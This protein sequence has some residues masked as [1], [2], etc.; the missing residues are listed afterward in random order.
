MAKRST[1]RPPARSARL[2]FDGRCTQKPGRLYLH[3]FDW[4]KDRKLLV[5]IANDVRAAY[6]LGKPAEKLE[7]APSADGKTITL[8]EI[9]PDPNATVVVVEIEGPLHVTQVHE[10][11]QSVGATP[12]QSSS[13]R[14]TR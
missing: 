4:P 11:S 9:T 14:L 12:D 5:P 10:D 3:V 8:P 7:V 13:K 1:A 2:P 6:L